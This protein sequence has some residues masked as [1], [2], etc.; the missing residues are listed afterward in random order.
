MV[1]S[2]VSTV[3]IVGVFHAVVIM[4]AACFAVLRWARGSSM[5]VCA[6]AWLVL[7]VLGG[8]EGERRGEAGRGEPDEPGDHGYTPSW[9]RIRK[10]IIVRWKFLTT[11]LLQ[12]GMFFIGLAFLASNA[13]S[14]KIG[15]LV[16]W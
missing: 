16:H 1:T 10:T 13:R 9:N 6:R 11:Q 7:A 2:L 3:S 4:V 8:E 15:S 12:T 5:A 14:V